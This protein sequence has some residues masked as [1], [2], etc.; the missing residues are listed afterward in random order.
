[1]NDW[2]NKGHLVNLEVLPP[3][4][5]LLE[6]EEVMEVCGCLN[7]TALNHLG[8]FAAQV[9]FRGLPLERAGAKPL[10]YARAPWTFSL[11]S[12]EPGK[13]GPTGPL[14]QPSWS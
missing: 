4:E 1:M 12:Q 5:T 10:L 13:M 11:F 8:C 6:P 7:H 9:Q 2:D 3:L 14:S